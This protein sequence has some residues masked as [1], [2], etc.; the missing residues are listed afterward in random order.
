MTLDLNVN[1]TLWDEKKK[2]FK[3]KTLYTSVCVCSSKKVRFKKTLNFE[4]AVFI[5][6]TQRWVLSLPAWQINSTD[7]Q[8]QCWH[9]HTAE[10]WQR[11]CVIEGWGKK[12]GD[13]ADY[14]CCSSHWTTLTN[15]GKVYSRG[16]SSHLWIRF[17]RGSISFF[18]SRGSS[19]V[20]A[21]NC[22]WPWHVY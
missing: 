5:L 2:M 14:Y 1:W 18:P 4:R 9:I 7:L 17:V 6:N 10:T 3:D 11:Y 19:G 16:M 15:C 8:S 21:P 20:R 22:K 13:S 12:Q